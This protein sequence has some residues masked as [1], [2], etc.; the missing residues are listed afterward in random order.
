[1]RQLFARKIVP[2][3][4]FCI[5]QSMPLTSAS[6]K[7]RLYLNHAFLITMT[8][9]SI[10]LLMNMFTTYDMDNNIIDG[11]KYFRNEEK[12]NTL[13]SIYGGDDFHNSS[14]ISTSSSIIH[15]STDTS[16]S[17]TNPIASIV[18]S[19][20]GTN[21]QSQTSYKGSWGIYWM[22]IRYF[23]N[24][25]CD[26]VDD[27]LLDR[28]ISNRK[29]KLY[30]ITFSC[31]DIYHSLMDAGT[32]NYMLTFYS[33]RRMAQQIGN[34]DVT[35]TCEDAYAT[36]DKLILPWLM[37]SF[38]RT[39]WYNENID[40]K[41]LIK[42]YE[43]SNQSCS[44]M[45][46]PEVNLSKSCNTYNPLDMYQDIIFELRRMAI[47]LVGTLG[48]DHPAHS[49]AEHHLW[50]EN[51]TMVQYNNKKMQL[52]TP[53]K[54][55]RPLLSNIEIDDV[56]FHYRCGDIMESKNKW[57][58]FMKFRSYSKRLA[59]EVQQLQQHNHFYSIGIVTQPF[60]GIQ[61]RKQDQ[62][63]NAV[64]KCRKVL[65][66]FKT[67]LQEQNYT[68]IEYDKNSGRPIAKKVRVT[69]RNSNKDFITT[70]YARLIMA[71][72]AVVAGNSWFAHFA[73]LASFA[74]K[75]YMH[76]NRLATYRALIPSI[77][78]TDEYY[79]RTYEIHKLWRIDNG[80]TVIQKLMS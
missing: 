58:G 56:A 33:F 60:L 12:L 24:Y 22:Y 65:Y 76:R 63:K 8:L 55:D 35:I 5:H 20:F 2:K 51:N 7:N 30:N 49:W 77:H 48:L 32:G 71:R 17:C 80:D 23:T 1:M 9:A 69:I 74:T 29:N 72:H 46:Q 75:V 11:N 31:N 42:A 25:L 47:A 41:S 52:P 67:F 14:P 78:L 15:L 79:L 6:A 62:S 43:Y 59:S 13:S 3:P 53:Q 37:G 18:P 57:Y 4:R 16:G 66:A 26:G 10:V 21:I 50:Q 73:G 19:D 39:Y 64:D 36:K 34:I 27:Q 40:D 70:A 28:T 54:Y 44:Y 61:G 68:Y 45:H 38:P